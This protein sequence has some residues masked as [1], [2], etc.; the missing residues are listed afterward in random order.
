MFLDKNERWIR[1]ARWF[2]FLFPSLTIQPQIQINLI[3]SFIIPCI[4]LQ[5]SFEVESK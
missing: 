2:A 1:A 4:R 5:F 3:Q